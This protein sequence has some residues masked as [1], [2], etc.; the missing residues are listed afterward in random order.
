MLEPKT[1]MNLDFSYQ[2]FFENSHDVDQTLKT[3]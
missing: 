3:H 1:K 2:S